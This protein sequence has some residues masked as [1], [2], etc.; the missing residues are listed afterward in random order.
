MAKTAKSTSSFDFTNI[1]PE[2]TTKKTRSVSVDSSNTSTSKGNVTVGG[3]KRNYYLPEDI[4][5]AINIRSANDGVGKNELVQ[6]ALREYL[7]DYL[8]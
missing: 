8:K 1:I 5:K 2:K 7:K 6:M 3:I 4:I